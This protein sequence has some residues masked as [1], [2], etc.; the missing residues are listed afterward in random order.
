MNGGST[1]EVE[2]LVQCSHHNISRF[3]LPFPSLEVREWEK[4][5]IIKLAFEPTHSHNAHGLTEHWVSAHYKHFCVR[6]ILVEYNGAH[7]ET[8][9][10]FLMQH[11]LFLANVA[12]FNK[13]KHFCYAYFHLFQACRRKLSGR[14]GCNNNCSLYLVFI[15][16]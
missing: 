10:A 6:A 1:A 11:F 15:I 3:F 9:A 4:I 12:H 2:K 5:D 7:F 13:G 8:T 16:G 14:L